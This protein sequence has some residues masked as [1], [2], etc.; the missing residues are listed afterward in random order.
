M[1]FDFAEYTVDW[2]TFFTDL[3]VTIVGGAIGF[4]TALWFYRRQNTRDKEDAALA[5][6]SVKLKPKPVVASNVSPP[7]VVPLKTL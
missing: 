4:W 5:V 3:A 6:E 1:Y 2:W 7:G